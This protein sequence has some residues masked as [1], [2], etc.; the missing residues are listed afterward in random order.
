[1]NEADER[2]QPNGV[3]SGR[4][5]S[6]SRLGDTGAPHGSQRAIEANGELNRF[7]ERCEARRDERTWSLNDRSG[8]GSIAAGACDPEGVDGTGGA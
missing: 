2:P 5:T 1:V 4:S 6:P 8:E 3:R 7:P